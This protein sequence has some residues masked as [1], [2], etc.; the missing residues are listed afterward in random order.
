[1]SAAAEAQRQRALLAALWQGSDADALPVLQQ[2]GERAA[3]GL[4]AY[5]ANA[6]ALAERA[7]GAVFPTVQAMLGADDFSHLAREFRRARP[8]ERGDMG[9]WG[10]DL[11]GWLEAHGAFADW[12]YLGDGARLDLAV[13]RC[14]RAADAEL[15][16]ASFGL[17]ESIDPA[18]LRIVLMPGT[19]ALPSVWPLATIHRAHAM[20]DDADAAAAAFAE[21]RAALAA[22]RGE[23]VVVMRSGWR[24]QVHAVDAPTLAWTQSLLD[25]VPLGRALAQA[26]AGFDFTAWLTWV[27]REGGVKEV[28]R[29]G[30]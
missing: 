14:E 16:G 1:M 26:D 28:Q 8:P 25:G 3:Q 11:P 2:V 21:V 17:L 15:D 20:R 22:Q 18:Q 23:P 9:E 24:A 12:P 29:I 10:D 5:R 30:D 13:H 7:L 19:A 4:S 27:L 6:G